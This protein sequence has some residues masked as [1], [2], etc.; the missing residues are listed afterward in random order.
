MPYEDDDDD[1]N[2]TN[3]HELTPDDEIRAENEINKLN[4][5]LKGGKFFSSGDIPPE[6]EKMFLDHIMQFEEAHRNAKVIKVYEYLHSPSWTPEKE[7]SEAD[8]HTELARILDIMNENGL[9]L[10]VQ[11]EYEERVIYKFITEELFEVERQDIRLPG[12][13]N[14][15]VYEDFHPN[16]TLDS[17]AATEDFVQ[18]LLSNDDEE[19]D[20]FYLDEAEEKEE[21]V[22]YRR[23]LN[24]FCLDKHNNEIS[25]D[26]VVEKIM[27][28]RSAFGTIKEIEFEV[29]TTEILENKAIVTFQLSYSAQIAGSLQAISFDGQGECIL[30]RTEKGDYWMVQR[31]KFPGFEV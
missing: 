13:M 21:G 4:L 5:E 16:D 1:D 30:V 26:K 3:D 29:E 27:A 19:E 17:N 14:Q 12:M 10:D 7:L 15:Y 24:P 20:D 6:I 11:G 28:F 8:I 22:A 31:I 25:R 2:D 9:G 23:E 18:L